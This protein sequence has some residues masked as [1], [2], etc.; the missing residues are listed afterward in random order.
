MEANAISDNEIIVR[1]LK[2]ITD[3]YDYEIDYEKEGK[4]IEIRHW[5][6]YGPIW[7]DYIYPLK[8][9]IQYKVQFLL[10]CAWNLN[11]HNKN[12]KSKYEKTLPKCKPIFFRK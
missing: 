7:S 12:R 4:M 3:D 2:P 1:F 8:P 6:T 11:V 5:A 9:G 10:R